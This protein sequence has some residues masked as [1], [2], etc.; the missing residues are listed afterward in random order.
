MELDNLK[1][2]WRTLE[3]K[4]G[5]GPTS[6]QLRMLMLKRSRGPVNRMKRNLFRELLLV[7]IT[8]TPAILFYLLE[9]G[10]KLSEIAGLFV[11]VLFLFAAYFYRKYK[12]LTEMECVSCQI[13]AN[14]E[15]QV[16]TL[17]KYVRF[18]V[19]AGT[20]MIPVLTILCF[21]IIRWKFPPLPGSGI[22]YR[23]SSLPW[24]ETSLLGLIVLA[25]LTIGIYYVNEWYV[26]KLYGRHI[27]KLQQ[28]LQEMDEG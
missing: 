18:Y 3:A 1:Y 24:R 13:R 10:G 9:F 14:L 11:I 25:P 16:G 21:M 6:E 26:N 19:I 7:G 15:L 8:Y 12:L 20:L 4:P 5:A 28:L 27:K 2:M 23:I 22:F 17:K